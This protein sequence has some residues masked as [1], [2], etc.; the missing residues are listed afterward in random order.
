MICGDL[1][2]FLVQ[3]TVT[4]DKIVVAPH[5]YNEQKGIVASQ[6]NLTLIK[7]G[8]SK[9]EPV[10]L[11]SDA[12][13]YSSLQYLYNPA[14]IS[15]EA[16]SSR[17]KR[18][19]KQEL[20]SKNNLEHGKRLNDFDDK[21]N[22]DKGLPKSNK[23]NNSQEQKHSTEK[24]K[25]KQNSGKSHEGDSGE[26]APKRKHTVEKTLINSEKNPHKPRK[27]ISDSNDS[28]SDSSSSSSSSSDSD[29]DSDSSSISMPSEE[30]YWQPRP[31]LKSAPNSPLLPLFIGYS[32]SSI[33]AS[34]L[35][36]VETAQKLASYV[37]RNLAR[38]N[39]LNPQHTLSG[40]S[41]LVTLLQT[42]NE[43]Q[44]RQSAAKVYFD[45]TKASQKSQNDAN[46]YA[47][48]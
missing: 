9:E 19:A 18:S 48:W 10:T 13:E 15:E 46:Q 28:S 16:R 32:G 22:N 36:G 25:G 8:E 4:T 40:F 5:L 23:G 35:N 41:R 42:M 17:S 29:S 7:A 21:A 33:Q 2:N 39:S 1:E 24:S 3:S 12:Q 31:S 45:Y 44:M 38:R 14:G 30:G 20:T 43:E 11:P 26:S 27:N 47:A 34:K 6:F 37:G